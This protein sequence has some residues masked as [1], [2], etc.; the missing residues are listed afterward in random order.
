MNKDA[1]LS[2][3]ISKA[4]FEALKIVQQKLKDRAGEAASVSLASAT[5]YVI[6]KGLADIGLM[7]GFMDA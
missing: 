2:I 1:A 6:Q 3:R 4:D 7:K 5:R